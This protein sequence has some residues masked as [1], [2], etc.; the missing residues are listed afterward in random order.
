M[1]KKQETNMSSVFVRNLPFETTNAQLEEHFSDV[2]RS[3][4]LCHLR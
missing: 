1:S 2:G 3:R 4:G